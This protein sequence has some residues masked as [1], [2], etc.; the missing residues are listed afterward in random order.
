MTCFSSPQHKGELRRNISMHIYRQTDRHTHTHTHTP[1]LD[2]W[3]TILEKVVIYKTKNERLMCFS[4]SKND[5]ID[6]SQSKKITNTMLWGLVNGSEWYQRVI[7]SGKES[8]CSAGDP[9]MIPGLGR[10]PE[11]EMTTHSSS[12]AWR[13]PTIHR[14]TKLDTTE[15]LTLLLSKS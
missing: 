10:S 1:Y 14:I 13:I 3:L 9:G 2:L 15:Q 6:A 4:L 12:L 8:V 7:E 11:E 5:W